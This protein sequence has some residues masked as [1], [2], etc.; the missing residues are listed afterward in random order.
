LAFWDSSA[1]VP[2]LCRQTETSIVRQH[3][4]RLGRII[5]WWGTPVEVQS[6]LARLRRDGEIT[7]KELDQAVKKLVMLRDSWSEIMPS[8]RL[9]EVA[10]TLPRTNNVRAADA[11][12]L[13][14]ALVW[15]N[16]H[17]RN[18]PFVCF[19]KLLIAAARARGFAVYEYSTPRGGKKSRV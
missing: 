6:A 5:V 18:K 14:A 17:P 7:D 19:D 9:R 11:F 4:R 16:E 12:Q 10:E 15:T 1:I 8:A 13:A 3:W 2:L